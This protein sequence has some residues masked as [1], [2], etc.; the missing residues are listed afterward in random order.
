MVL[1]NPDFVERLKQN[2]PMNEADPATFFVGGEK[3]Y[4]DYPSL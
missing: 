1:A 4:T 3:G 2:A